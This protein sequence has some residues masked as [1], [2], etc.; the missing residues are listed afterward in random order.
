MRESGVPREEIFV[1]TKLASSAHHRVKEAFEDSLNKLNIGYIDL[2]LMHAP[3]ASING[4][5]EKIRART[6]TN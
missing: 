5:Q 3:T 4:M 1:V 2:W 6:M